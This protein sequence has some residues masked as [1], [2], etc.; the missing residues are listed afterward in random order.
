M[1]ARSLSRRHPRKGRKGM[2]FDPSRTSRGVGLSEENLTFIP[3]DVKLRSL[4]D[5]MIVEPIDVI[6]SRILV[7]P[8]QDKTLRAKVLTVGPGHYPTQYDHRE[9]HKRTKAWAGL[10][11]MPTEVKVGDIVR[12]EG[13]NSEG[14]FWG[15]KYCVH[16]REQDVCGIEVDG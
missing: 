9:K 16:A 1:L 7:L 12:L 13:F 8:P 2:R 14:F 10:G 15:T 6:R 11:F 5:Q 4:R 3:A